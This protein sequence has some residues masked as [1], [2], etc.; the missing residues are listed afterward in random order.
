MQTILQQTGWAIKR[1]LFIIFYLLALLSGGIMMY[2]LAPMTSY[3]FFRD[4]RFW[5][6]TRYFFTGMK[7]FYHQLGLI[8]TDKRYRTMF[9]IPLIAPPLKQPDKSIIELAAT[10]DSQEDECRGC[11]RCCLKMGCALFDQEKDICM[12]YD[13]FYWRYFNCGRYP[14]TQK[15]IDYYECTKWVMKPDNRVPATI[16]TEA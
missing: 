4:C 5:R 11:S 10:W 15:Q 2:I 1:L 9:S 6:Y 14:N 16:D 7:T 8:I 13:S 12:S 3:L